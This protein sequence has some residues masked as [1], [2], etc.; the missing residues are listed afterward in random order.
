MIVLCILI[1]LVIPDMCIALGMWRM[2]SGILVFVAFVFLALEL[3]AQCIAKRGLYVFS[4]FMLTDIIG[5]MSVYFRLCV[6]GVEYPKYH[7]P[8]LSSLVLLRISRLGEHFS[9]LLGKCK[10]N[11]SACDT[12]RSLGKD[13]EESLAKY[14]SLTVALVAISATILLNPPG[15]FL[16]RESLSLWAERLLEDIRTNEILF[17]EYFKTKQVCPIS[18]SLY[19]SNGSIFYTSENH[20][21][22]CVPEIEYYVSEFNYVNNETMGRFEAK[23]STQEAHQK[24]AFIALLIHSTVF[25][26]VIFLTGIIHLVSSRCVLRP[27]EQ[28]LLH[29]TPLSR[30]IHSSVRK[31]SRASL[32]S[33]SSEASTDDRPHN[34]EP[35]RHETRILEQISVKLNN[36]LQLHQKPSQDTLAHTDM[37]V[38]HSL[39]DATFASP[40]T[41][42][43][44]SKYDY[45]PLPTIFRDLISPKTSSLTLE[46]IN[47][48]ELNTLS[49]S[50]TENFLL[51]NYIF[52]HSPQRDLLANHVSTDLFAGFLSSIQAGYNPNPYHGFAHA[53]DVTHTVYRIIEL[54]SASTFLRSM[55][56]LGLLIAGLM[57]DLGHHGVNNLFLSETGH[58][59]ATR[60]NDRSPLE[61]FH[62]AKF[63]ELLQSVNILEWLSK[64][65]YKEI[66]KV[67]IDAVLHTDNFYHFG[68]VKDLNLFIELNR[69]AIEQQRAT[70]RAETSEVVEILKRA[71]S[72]SLMNKLFLH[73]ADISNPTKPYRICQE[74]AVLVMEEFFAQGD[75]ERDLG[76]SIQPL[77]D[78][79]TVNIAQAQVSFIEFVVA[80]LQMGILRIFPGLV[81]NC[82]FLVGNMVQWAS[83]YVNGSC[84]VSLEDEEKMIARCKR[85]AL[86]FQEIPAMGGAFVPESFRPLRPSSLP[87]TVISNSP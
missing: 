52:L 74:W 55:D 67:I 29:I 63:F 30:S 70:S 13:L 43:T 71:D 33:S 86:K 38:I 28:F 44:P 35:F 4:V 76:I 24:R 6:V 25:F 42:T 85:V 5:T 54:S 15:D 47:S 45:P 16:N 59:L 7:F 20:P 12:V 48:W 87:N 32:G 8:S 51:L 77:N 82:Q 66:R 40:E 50:H 62:C 80:P 57:H 36:L 60:F 69:G 72:R 68:M 37:A 65:Q 53:V 11:N 61:N 10:S 46:L 56:R 41:A 79:N 19:Q 23:I 17:Y 22:K 83:E 26:S 1:V 2:G 84:D 18:F 3:V 39:N 81:D 64:E 73:A 49:L 75:L 58:E 31:L 78:R 9:F 34:H 27:L 21:L 14:G